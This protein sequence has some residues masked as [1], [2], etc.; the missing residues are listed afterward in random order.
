MLSAVTAP[1]PAQP[2]IL[3]VASQTYRVEPFM[4]SVYMP[5]PPWG[6]VCPAIASLWKQVKYGITM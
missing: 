6:V 3:P 2:T 5:P 4:R 1:F